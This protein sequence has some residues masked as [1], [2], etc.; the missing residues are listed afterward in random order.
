MNVTRIKEMCESRGIPLA[1]FGRR[2]GIDTR[3]GISRRLKNQYTIT[4]DE[5]IRMARELGVTVEDLSV[6]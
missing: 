1:E 3:E 5:L 4:G 6:T 2:V